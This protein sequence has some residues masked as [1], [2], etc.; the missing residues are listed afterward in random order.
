MSTANLK[1][2]SMRVIAQHSR[3]S[4]SRALQMKKARRSRK[5]QPS[6]PNHL[7]SRPRRS[8]F[9]FSTWLTTTTSSHSS[10]ITSSVTAGPSWS[11]CVSS[12][13]STSQEPRPFH[14][15]LFSIPIGLFGNGISS[16]VKPEKRSSN[17]GKNASPI[18]PLRLS[19]PHGHPKTTRLIREHITRSVLGLNSQP[20]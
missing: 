15:S 6:S 5:S 3:S 12:R 14:H 11:L 8:S 10:R 20:V 9:A 2:A 1:S 17:I 13:S 7:T 18:S 4:N 19:F 16:P